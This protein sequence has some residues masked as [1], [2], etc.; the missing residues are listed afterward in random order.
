MI[1]YS[2]NKFATAALEHSVIMVINTP[3]VSNI[4]PLVWHTLFMFQPLFKPLIP[5]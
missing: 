3:T 2:P 4:I 1:G 5:E